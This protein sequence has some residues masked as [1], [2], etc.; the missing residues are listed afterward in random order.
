MLATPPFIDA[1]ATTLC[2][3]DLHEGKTDAFDLMIQLYDA[4][5]TAS[6]ARESIAIG[7]RDAAK[8]AATFHELADVTGIV[9]AAPDRPHF[10]KEEFEDEILS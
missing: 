2:S 6:P 8:N 1:A 4:S 7:L 10:R 3:R 5:D 9:V